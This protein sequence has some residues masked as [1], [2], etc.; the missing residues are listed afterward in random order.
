MEDK[1]RFTRETLAQFYTLE[2]MA[3]FATT[4]LFSVIPTNKVALAVIEGNVLKPVSTIGER[5]FMDLNLDW[6]SI[7]ARAVKTRHTQLVND[8][9]KDPDY[10]PGEGGDNIT[11]L[12]ELC[13]PMIHR[14]KVLGTINFESRHLGH[15]SEEDAETAEAFTH[16]IAEAIHRVWGNLGLVGGSPFVYQVKNR[17]IMDRYYDLLRAVY[18]GETVL[19]RVLNKTVIPWKP[20]KGMVDDLVTKGYLIRKQTSARRY[21]YRI[22]DEG[23]KALKTYEGIIEKL[24]E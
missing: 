20:G 19:N 15:F 1:L 9:R 3:M 18:E 12:S 6:P 22:T 5:V 14:S 4:M 10:I 7:N 21:A 24:G 17:S 23:V 2:D 11:M 13:V 16:E 8:T